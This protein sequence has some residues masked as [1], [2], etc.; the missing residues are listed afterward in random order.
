MYSLSLVKVPKALVFWIDFG[1]AIL[2]VT[3][4]ALIPDNSIF[5]SSPRFPQIFFSQKSFCF[6]ISLHL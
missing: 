5:S 6:T 2:L 4:L 1:G 3:G